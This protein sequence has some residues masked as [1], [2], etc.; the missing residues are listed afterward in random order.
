M[1]SM[2]KTMLVFSVVVVLV[3][4]NAVPECYYA[5]SE[6]MP[7]KTCATA[8]D[9]GDATADCLYSIN[10]GKHICCKPKAGAVLPKC[11]NNRQILSVG[12]NTGVV[13]T[14]SDQCP[15]SY[16]CVESTTNFDK[17]AGQGNKIC[18]H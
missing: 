13:C 12:K 7:G 5:W 16:E 14:S 8:S 9:C 15:D 1:C 4:V 11:P 18:C 3:T 17:L 2:A 10:D 6:R